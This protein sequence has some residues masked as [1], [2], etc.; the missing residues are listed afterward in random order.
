[1]LRMFLIS[2]RLRV[3]TH[4]LLQNIVILLIIFTG[5]K[6]LKPSGSNIILQVR[7]PAC[8]FLL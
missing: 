2:R 3:S 7:N 4:D 6:S 5:N 1:M 8:L